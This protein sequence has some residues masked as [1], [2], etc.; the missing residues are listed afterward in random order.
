MAADRDSPRAAPQ[1]ALKAAWLWAAGTA[2]AMVVGLT[3]EVSTDAAR[4][5]GMRGPRC[6]LG[7]CVGELH[8]PGCG[9]VRST[10]SAL[11]GDF[12]SAWQCHPGGLAVALLIPM[13]FLVHLDIIR[14]RDEMGL[15]RRLRSAGYVVFVAAVLLGWIARYL[16]RT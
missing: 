14:R 7:A 15:H 1:G 9:L 12:A 4:W 10:S 8:C 2:A 3:A 11:Q 13:T 6:P 5:F 16:I